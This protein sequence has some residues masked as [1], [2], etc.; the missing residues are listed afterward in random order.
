M[1]AV[2]PAPLS[3]WMLVV[4]ERHVA[5]A[6]GD[7]LIGGGRGGGLL[8]A[9]EARQR[10]VGHVA[11]AEHHEDRDGSLCVDRYDHGHLDVD[12]DRGMSGV[13]DVPDHPPGDDRLPADGRLHG[14]GHRPRDLRHVL[15]HAA[16]DLAL[17]VLHDLGTALL[18]PHLRG[19]DL[20]AVLQGQDVRPVRVGVGLGGVVVRG[21]RHA[22]GGPAV[23]ARPKL[24]DAQLSQHVGVVFARELVESGPLLG[25]HQERVRRRGRGRGCL[26]RGRLSPE[27]QRGEDAQAGEK[28]DA[29]CG[30]A[31]RLTLSGDEPIA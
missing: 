12:R 15:G 13:V 26:G 9:R 25:A 17:E 31:W 28:E 1:P 7:E 5:P 19:R 16:V 24:R 29:P 18:P 21:V 22:G 14:L 6:G 20:L 30:G 4:A 11:P 8:E 27:A 3:A 10:V 2:R 23:V